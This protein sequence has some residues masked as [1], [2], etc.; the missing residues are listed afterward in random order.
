MN[1]EQ[2][3]KE[4]LEQARQELRACGS[5]DCNAA[6][7]IFRLFPELQK[8][9]DERVKSNIIKLLRFVRDTYHQYSDECTQAID[10]LEKQGGQEPIDKVESKFKIG[11]WVVDI[12]FP[13]SPYKVIEVCESWYET[14][15]VDGFHYSIS[16]K[17]EAKFRPWT[18]QDAKNGDVLANKDGCVFIYNP[19]ESIGSTVRSYCYLSVQGNFL[20][21]DYNTGSWL[22][23][24]KITQATREQRDFLFAKM[25]EA[26]YKWDSN[27]KELKKVK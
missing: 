17:C 4:A 10:W 14:I 9:E 27:K 8:S 26:G 2:K 16:F 23:V 22:Y 18:I 20:L 21:E 6:R 11:D 3:Y 1:Y 12:N 19:S 7:R 24:N 25:K 13:R 15:D 5:M